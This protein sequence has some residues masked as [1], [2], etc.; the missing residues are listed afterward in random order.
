VRDIDTLARYGGDE[1]VVVLGELDREQAQS[2]QRT[3]VIAER[4]RHDLGAPYPL[5]IAR[6]GQADTAIEH[7]CTAS[8]GMTLFKGHEVSADD[9]LARADS[10]MYGAKAAGRNR[11]QFA[12]PNA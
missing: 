5:T 12:S 4:I 7:R 10:A 8:I 3:Q 6:D 11:V 1:F 9:L 2:L